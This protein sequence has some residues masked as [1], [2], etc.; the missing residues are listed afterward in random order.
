MVAIALLRAINVGGRNKLPMAQWKSIC[1]SLGLSNVRT[2]IQS[3]NAAF[4][5]AKADLKSLAGRMEEAIEQA[6]GFRP[7]V[8]VRTQQEVVEVVRRNPFAGRT[9]L[10]PGYLLVNFLPSQPTSDAITEAL[11]LAEPFPE[12]LHVLGRELYTYYPNGRGT[13]KLPTAR[14]ERLLGSGTERNWNTVQILT[15]L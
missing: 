10:T 7:P 2:Y 4:D 13:T 8:I 15:T 12:E 1:E 6:C 3:G 14:I 9:G 11:K 5:I